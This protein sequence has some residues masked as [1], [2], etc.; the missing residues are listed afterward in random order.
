MI[1][2]VQL[3]ITIGIP[4]YTSSYQAYERLEELENIIADAINNSD[5]GV[6]LGG[7]GKLVRGEQNE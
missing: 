5:K 3:T 1:D 7:K 4:P 2:K 6:F